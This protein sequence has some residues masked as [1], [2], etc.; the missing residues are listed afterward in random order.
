MYLNN[1]KLNQNKKVNNLNF[2]IPTRMNK[3]KITLKITHIK[4]T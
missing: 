2:N 4:K 1:P 3:I